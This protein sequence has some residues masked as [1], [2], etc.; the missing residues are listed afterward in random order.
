MTITTLM[1]TGKS[2]MV[3]SFTP[4]AFGLWPYSVEGVYAIVSTAGSPPPWGTPIVIRIGKTEDLKRRQGQYQTDKEVLQYNPTHF[5]VLPVVE[6]WRRTVIE[7][8]LIPAH[9]PPANHQ[10]V[11]G[12]QPK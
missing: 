4:Y 6:A 11:Q 3:Y 10:L 5:C 7:Y 12:E 2:G 9:N 8:D 1:L